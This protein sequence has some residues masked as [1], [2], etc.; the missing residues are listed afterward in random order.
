MKN[1]CLIILF[2]AFL[3][4]SCHRNKKV[5][6]LYNGIYTGQIEHIKVLDDTT[7]SYLVYLPYS[8]KAKGKLPIIW[9]FDAHANADSIINW[10]LPYAEYYNYIIVASKNFRNNTQN[11][12]YILSTFFEDV[13]KKIVYNQQRQYT[14]GF[15]GG[16]RI[17]YYLAAMDQK[18]DGSALLSA[19]ITP[20]QFMKNKDINI[21]MFAGWKDFNLVEIRG[22]A[23]SLAKK[24]GLPYTVFYFNGSH[25]YPPHYYAEYVFLWFE[26]NAIKKGL[27]KQKRKI[28]ARIKELTDSIIQ[29]NNDLMMQYDLYIAEKNMLALFSDTMKIVEEIKSLEK[30]EEFTQNARLVVNFFNLESMLRPQ[31]YQALFKRDTSWWAREINAYKKKIKEDTSLYRNFFYHRILS[32]LSIMCYSV[33]S[34]LLSQG[35]LEKADKVLTIYEMIEA[36]NPDVYLLRSCYWLNRTEVAKG[37]EYFK[38]SLDLGFSEYDRLKQYKC[39]EKVYDSLLKVLN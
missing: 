5:S 28:I 33:S 25:N 10:L 34:N 32:Y 19:G 29:V 27:A 23:V 15:S 13:K 21:I 11:L 6:H 12:D 4:F 9:A 31:Y 35:D 2:F 30:R 7:Q 17:A 1:K 37:M 39:F 24:L 14:I 26:A 16:A 20:I 3:L 22:K 18:F 36:D 8:Y 38:K